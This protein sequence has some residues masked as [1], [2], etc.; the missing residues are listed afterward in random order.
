MWLK[1]YQ[2]FEYTITELQCNH[3]ITTAV[4]NVITWCVRAMWKASPYLNLYPAN[5]ENMLSS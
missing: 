3:Y 2:A 4:V 1:I 5:V